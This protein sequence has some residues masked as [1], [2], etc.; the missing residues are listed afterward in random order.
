MATRRRRTASKS[1]PEPEP[2]A[3]EK[4]APREPKPVPF[5][6]DGRI[7]RPPDLKR[8]FQ[9]IVDDLFDS[10]F[11]VAEE[12]K[13]IR[14]RLVI[15]DALTPGALKRDANE[16]EEL[17]ER[18]YQLY[19][20]GKVEIAAYMRESES[21]YGAMRQSAKAMLEK[22]KAAKEITKSITEADVV[23]EAARLYPDEWANICTLRDRAEAM[24]DSL[25]N[26]ATLAKSRCFTVS[27]MVSSGNRD[28]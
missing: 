26:L 19:I 2:E 3:E 16:R 18:A 4:P 15:K 8:G 13:N 17:A 10:G 12:W 7:P 21:T 14:E 11:D 27:N 6:D 25:R 1:E 24:L 9:T 5:M 22:M 20:V 23:A 28:V